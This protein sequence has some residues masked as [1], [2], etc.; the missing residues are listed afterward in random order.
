MTELVMPHITRLKQI[1]RICIIIIIIIIH[2]Y[3]SHYIHS[4][5][6][7]TKIPLFYE[8]FIF[9]EYKFFTLKDQLRTIFA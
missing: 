6:V 3:N 2:G 9:R 8:H 1:K 5:E 7:I 4:E